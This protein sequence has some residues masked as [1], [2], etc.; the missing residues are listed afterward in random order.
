MLSL[1]LLLFVLGLGYVS[2][3]MV[4]KSALP[5]PLSTRDSSSTSNSDA[6]FANICGE[7]ID[8]VND[9]YF[10]FYASAAYDCLRSVPFNDAVALRFIDYYNM[11]MQFHSTVSLLRNPPE[12]YQQPA[13]DILQGLANLRGNVTTNIYKNQYAF[14][15]DLQY[16]IYQMHDTHVDLSAGILA[17]F[18]FAS[19]M[20]ILSASIDGTAEP[21]IWFKSDIIDYINNPGGPPPSP[22][23]SING[24]DVVEY[25]TR[26]AALN[27]QGTLEPHADW[28]QLMAS[29][30]IDIQYSVSYFTGAATFYPGD[31]LNFTQAN[32]TLTP[33]RWLAYYNEPYFTGPL[34]TGG[35]FYNYFVLGNLPASYDITPLPDI[36]N[37]SMYAAS[38]LETDPIIIKNWSDVTSAYPENPIVIQ[39]GLYPGSGAILTAYLLPEISTSVLS[40]PTFSEFDSD[41]Q[42]FA[43]AI[44][45]F[46]GNAT[47]QGLKKVIIDLQ[48]NT[49]GDVLLAFSAFK[50]FFPQSIPFA[51][52]HRRSHYLGN[53]LGKTLTEFWDGL[54]LDDKP[55]WEGNEWVVTPRINAATGRNFTSWEEYAGPIQYGAD[56]FSLA[57]RYNLSNV[58][59][60]ESIF[61]GWYPVDY[62][63]QPTE[64]NPWDPSNI[65]ILTDGLCASTCSLFVEMMTEAG[66]R[67]VA[68]GGRPETG[69]M[70][71]AS[72]TRGAATY[73]AA[74]LDNDF[75]NASVIVPLDNS[76]S[77]DL[78]TLNTLTTIISTRDQGM[79]INWAGFT[80]R[81]QLSSID[82]PEPLQLKY[83]PADCRIYW[84]IDNVLNFTRLWSDVSAAIWDDQS[85]CVKGSTE[86]TTNRGNNDTEK[87]PPS[88]L[89][90]APPPP[91]VVPGVDFDASTTGLWDGSGGSKTFDFLRQKTSKSLLPT[92]RERIFEGLLCLWVH[93]HGHALPCGGS[94]LSTPFK[95]AGEFD[96]QSNQPAWPKQLWGLGTAWRL[97]ANEN[98]QGKAVKTRPLLIYDE[99]ELPEL[100]DRR[101]QDSNVI[102]FGLFQMVMLPFLI[103]VFGS[104]ALTAAASIGSLQ[105]RDGVNGDIAQFSL[106]W[107][108]CAGTVAAL[109]SGSH[110]E[111]QS[112]GNLVLYFSGGISFNTGFSD[113]SLPCSNPCNCRLILQEDGNLVTYINYGQ[114]NQV[115]G[116]N[117]GTVGVSSKTGT[118]ASYFEVFGNNVAINNF[119]FVAVVDSKG[120]GLYTTGEFSFQARVS[121]KAWN[122]DVIVV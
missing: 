76:E 107:S 58:L 1:M 59:F 110:L 94:D 106:G 39:D 20:E 46:I 56:D 101:C 118:K 102:A 7:I 57:E 113:P 17:A 25:L 48:Q 61:D 111:F 50:Q 82:D 54:S 23:V 53:I 34:T 29:P 24:E 19:P 38:Q 26:F 51:G 65:V 91:P 79:W 92:T 71:A 120:Y 55:E 67:T 115:V 8:D 30:A 28:N 70:Q 35:D 95:F 116:W 121:A 89:F 114:P 87:M 4:P 45:Q 81:D 12:G 40:L 60:D 21:E 90:D 112:D 96:K 10:V 43:T 93:K 33:M 13:F 66:V 3:S 72:G 84:T 18:T 31:E 68:V 80:L 27:S 119:P 15:A 2:A 117:S 5:Q 122:M 109:S 74:Q 83:K 108:T 98:R 97:P 47:S 44:D 73:T 49:G 22:I 63:E 41:I 105:R 42:P 69:P 77:S 62:V 99:N 52:S 78:D 36:F 88:R 6:P 32:G 64:P 103:T 9:G 37:E 16:L 11:T 86:F 100:N 85:L 14:E 104:G 75:W